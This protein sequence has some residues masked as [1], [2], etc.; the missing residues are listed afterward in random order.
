M[1]TKSSKCLNSSSVNSKSENVY[2]VAVATAGSAAGFDNLMNGGHENIGNNSVSLSAAH[3]PIFYQ[4]QG[5]GYVSSV[6]YNTGYGSNN[7]SLSSTA[8]SS[9]V[10]SSST[11]ATLTAPHYF[12]PILNASQTL[13]RPLMTTQPPLYSPILSGQQHSSY[14]IPHTSP[15]AGKDRFDVRN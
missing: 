2:N 7:S 12:S 9:T 1:S 14:G 13:F 8:S 10:S 6:H 5:N 15:S 4:G 3:T 11:A